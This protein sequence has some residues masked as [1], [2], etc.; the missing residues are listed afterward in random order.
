M[1]ATGW[2]PGVPDGAVARTALFGAGLAALAV[3]A[4]LSVGVGAH[5]IAPADVVRALVDY[6]GTPDQ[7]IVR[8]VRA[9][10]ALLA[11]AVGAALGV[12]GVLIQTLSR[13]PLAEPGVLGV[14]V[15]A[16]FAMTVG[17]AL[18]AASTP[19]AELV[20][21]MGGAVLAATLVYA[22]GRTSPLRLVLAGVALSAVLS[23]LSL[24]LRLML[25][26]TLD[27]YRFWYVGSLAGREQTPLAWPLAAI[28]VALL[29][30]LLLGRSLG[31]VALGEAVARTLGVSVV[32]VRFAALALITVLV[33]AATAVAG[34]ILFVGL[35]VPHVTRRLARG[36]VPWL[37][38]N[39][40]IVGAMLLLAADMGARVL[41][42]TGE[43]PV[44]IVTAFLGG[45]VLIWVVRRYGTG[46]L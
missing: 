1:T 22:V 10:R 31:A 5:S 37:T 27:A 35:I 29:G 45:P 26:D 23:G 30:A 3:L 17:L 46:T 20:L 36:S 41:L 7:T 40:M 42:P 25:P 24:G 32:R 39:S 14:T 8:D 44:A 21:S 9:P 6:D 38:A 19:L 16:A 33:G 34:P 12:A 43:M 15:G 11:I 28:G 4:V 2:R 18:G 13:N